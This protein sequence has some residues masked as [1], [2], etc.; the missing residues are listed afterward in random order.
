MGGA[1]SGGPG[2]GGLGTEGADKDREPLGPVYGLFQ[3]RVAGDDAL[4][5]LAG[6]RF[7]QFGPGRRGVCRHAGG[8]RACPAVRAAPSAPAHGPPE[9]RRQRAARAGP[10]RRSGNSPTASRAASRGLVV[11]DKRE[12]GDA[13]R[14]ACSACCAS[15]TRASCGGRPARSSSSSTPPAWS[16]AWFVE[17][18]ERLQDAERVSCCIDV[19]H[20]GIRQASARFARSHPGLSLRDLSPQD[21]RLPELAADVQD[22]VGRRRWGRARRHPLDR[23]GSASTCISTCTTGIPLIPGLPDHFT[24]L[25]RLPIPFSYQGRRS[26]SMMYGPGG[27]ASIVSAAIEACRPRR[28][29]LHAGDPPGRRP[30]AAGDASRAVP[31]LAGHHQRRTDEL[32]ALGARRERAARSRECLTDAGNGDRVG[33][34]GMRKMWIDWSLARHRRSCSGLALSETMTTWSGAIHDT[35]SAVP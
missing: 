11:H 21:D 22:A 16:P 1:W 29:V 18:A 10:R 30:A 27:L 28:G 24:F 17:V 8:A 33:G 5:E 2:L 34:A 19:G 32:L 15:S 26:L 14:P 23:R 6:L 20:V 4:L 12:M 31:P 3:R 7:T 9:P 35:P 13:D 25:T